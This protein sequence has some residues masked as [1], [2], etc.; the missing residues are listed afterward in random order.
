VLPVSALPVT[1]PPG[2]MPISSTRRLLAS[3][4]GL[5]ATTSRCSSAPVR[6][7][8]TIRAGPDGVVMNSGSRRRAR[9][10]GRGKPSASADSPTESSRSAALSTR[11][12]IG[13]RLPGTEEEKN[14]VPI[15]D[16]AWR[17]RSR[18]QAPSSA[19]PIISGTDAAAA[20]R[21]ATRTARPS[22]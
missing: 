15:A 19:D 10:T 12:R 22:A 11:P 4:P 1:L 6:E 17:A 16:S 5:P 8:R 13:S 3:T 21:T 14:V 7:T 2:A 18:C 9:E 20:A